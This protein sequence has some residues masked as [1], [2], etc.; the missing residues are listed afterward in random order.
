MLRNW[1]LLLVT[2]LL[3]WLGMRAVKVLKAARLETSAHATSPSG[4]NLEQAVMDAQRNLQMLMATRQFR[5]GM[6]ELSDVANTMNA[7]QGLA[8]EDAKRFRRSGRFPRRAILHVTERP[9]GPWQ[10]VLMFGRSTIRVS[11]Y[12]EDLTEPLL[13]RE[14]KC[15]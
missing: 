7:A 6:S 12:S 4:G 15:Q 2:V 13:V 10:V 5:C 14:V 8:P 11:G 3:V 1:F 9:T